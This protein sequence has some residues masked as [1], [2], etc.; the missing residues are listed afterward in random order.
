MTGREGN[1]RNYLTYRLELV[2]R[3]AR[4]AADEIYRR[5]CGSDIRQLRVLRTLAE[6]PDVTVSE[7]VEHTMFERTLVSRIITDLVRA[8]MVERRICEI[9]A[10]Q[11]RLSITRSGRAVL[12]GGRGD[13]GERLDELEER[14]REL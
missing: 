14:L 2:A 4:N 6:E 10:R 12:V 1:F 3:I 13:V 11:T 8:N 9:D 7:I 5:E